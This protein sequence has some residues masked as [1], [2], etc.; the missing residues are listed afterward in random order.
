MVVGI[1]VVDVV[2][3]GLGLVVA[4]V[5]FGLSVLTAETTR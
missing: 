4:A 5:V 3:F 1:A 2:I